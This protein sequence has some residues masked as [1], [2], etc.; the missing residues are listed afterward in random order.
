MKCI[1]YQDEKCCAESRNVYQN[2]RDM[3]ALMDYQGKDEG[4]DEEL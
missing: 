4:E 2:V 3:R 1:L